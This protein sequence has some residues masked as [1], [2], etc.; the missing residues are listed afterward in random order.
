MKSFTRNLLFFCTLFLILILGFLIGTRYS[1]DRNG[2]G[3]LSFGLGKNTKVSK[4]L[5]LIRKNYVDSVKVDSMENLAINEILKNLDPHSLYLPPQ[6]AKEQS[7]NLEGNFEG[8]GIEYYLLSDTIFVV[9]VRPN[10]PSQ[11]AG[12]L[13]G[14]KIVGVDGELFKGKGYLANNIISKLKGKKGSKV[15]VSVLRGNDSVLKNIEIVRDK[16]VVSSI[17]VAYLIN[18]I[19]GYIKISKFGASTDEDFEEELNRLNS[20]GM[21]NLILDLRGNGG[22]YL[23]S[24]TAL[25]DQFL[26]SGKLIVYTKGLHEPRTDYSATADGLFEKGDLVILIDEGTAS[27]S[28]VLAGAVQ[29]LDRGLIVGRRSFGKGLVQEQFFFDDGSAM[30]LTVARYYTPSGRSIQKSYENGREDYKNELNK[31][32]INGEYTS[33]DSVKADSVFLNE[34]SKFKT[35]NGRVVYGGGGIMPDY[36]IPIDT[37]YYSNFYRKVN[38]LGLIQEFVYRNLIQDKA[39]LDFKDKDDFSVRFKVSDQ[40]LKQF[41]DLAASKKIVI[42]KNELEISLPK[43]KKEIKAMLARYLYNEEGFYQVINQHEAAVLKALELIKNP[44]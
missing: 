22:G 41:T 12:I 10:G 31:R 21:K 7:E 24:A 13:R 3:V 23:N 30:N 16:I 40:T 25:A 17:D 9:S 6:Q 4:I 36:F 5:N 42:H 29:D 27:A 19:T 2:N 43:I 34:K 37:T 14:D 38:E 32:F 11:K 8:I 15:I 44:N 1:E 28:E 35:E 26:E 39:L 20:K 18:N 33:L